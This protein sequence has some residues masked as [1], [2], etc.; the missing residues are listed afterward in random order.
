MQDKINPN[1]RSIIHILNNWNFTYDGSYVRANLEIH[2]T[3]EEILATLDQIKKELTDKTNT[4]ESNISDDEKRQYEETIFDLTFA[5]NE[6][7][8]SNGSNIQ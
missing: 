4:S 8:R 1:L 7:E 5:L 6:L 2:I 3:K